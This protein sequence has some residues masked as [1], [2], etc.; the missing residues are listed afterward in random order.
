[1]AAR[2]VN[3][4]SHR[5]CTYKISLNNFLNIRSYSASK[6]VY[7]Q[8]IL[9]HVLDLELTLKGCTAIK[10]KR[11]KQAK[12]STTDKYFSHM[13]IAIFNFLRLF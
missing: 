2:L 1:M 6:F 13:C 12:K 10:Q 9:D 11:T 8:N 5:I 3:N 4:K 7:F